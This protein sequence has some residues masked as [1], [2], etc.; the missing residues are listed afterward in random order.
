MLIIYYIQTYYKTGE[1]GIA[2]LVLSEDTENLIKDLPYSVVKGS[3]Y[4]CDVDLIG[5]RCRIVRYRC[6][7]VSVCSRMP[8]EER[9][10]GHST[11]EEK[12]RRMLSLIETLSPREEID[13]MAAAIY[14]DLRQRVEEKSF[15]GARK[16]DMDRG[17]SIETQSAHNSP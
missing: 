8:E 9:R 3:G 4:D 2:H 17:F 15:C 11:V 16:L 6:G 7:S 12:D 13:R 14:R 5:Y 10:A 1:K